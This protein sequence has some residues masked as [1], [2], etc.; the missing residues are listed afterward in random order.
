MID[1]NFLDIDPPLDVTVKL[2]STENGGLHTPVLPEQKF[3][4]DM[5][6]TISNRQF[7]GQ[8][9]VQEKIFPGE[10]GKAI[11]VGVYPRDMV[12][13]FKSGN[14]IDLKMLKSIGVATIS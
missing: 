12:E 13:Y 3:R 1:D 5:F 7:W 8:L 4:P 14:Q 9:N 2:L 11:L 10:E 6:F